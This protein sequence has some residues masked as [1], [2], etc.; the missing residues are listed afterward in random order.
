MAQAINCCL[1]ICLS[2]EVGQRLINRD[3]YCTAYV[4]LLTPYFKVQH[5]ISILT[6]SSLIRKGIKYIDI[7]FFNWTSSKLALFFPNYKKGK[8][9]C[10]FFVIV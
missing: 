9:D 3:T 8:T 4:D 2:S 6:I 10:A 5:G 7:I 1:R